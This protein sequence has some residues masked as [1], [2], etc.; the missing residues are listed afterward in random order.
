LPGRRRIGAEWIDVGAAVNAVIVEYN[1]ADRQ[2]VPA[3]GLDLHA[4]KTEG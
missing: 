2:V 3:D 1:D 4:G